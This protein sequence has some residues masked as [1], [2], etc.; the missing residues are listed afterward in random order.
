MLKIENI[1]LGTW[2]Q[3]TSLHLREFFYFLET[4]KSQLG[5]DQAKL[6]YFYRKLNPAQVRWGEKEVFD[7]VTAKFDELE[8]AFFEDGIILIKKEY[9]DLKKDL[10]ILREFYEKKFS[11]TISYLYSLGAPLPKELAKI[12]LILPYIIVASEADEKEIKELFSELGD[13]VRSSAG[14]PEISLYFGTELFLLVVKEFKKEDIQPEEIIK[15]LIFFREFATQLNGYLQAHRTIWED[16]SQIRSKP[17]LRFRDFPE[18]RNSLMGIKQTL[19]FVEARLGQM[20]NF[21]KIRQSRAKEK[22]LDGVLRLL[23]IY[24]F[25]TLCNTHSY[26]TDLW[27]MTKDYADSTFSLLGMFYQENIQREVDALKL[28]TIISLAAALFRLSFLPI[29]NYNLLHPQF[30]GSLV[31][32]FIF[33]AIFYFGMRYWFRSRKFELQKKIKELKDR[34]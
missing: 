1:Y 2:F 28:I 33:A 19:S 27:K 25:D 22:G 13:S 23:S 5:L 17:A 10:R 12:E 3:R 20:E 7:N 24:E 15:Y 31:L 4:G 21:I 11:P 6:A 8:M 32:I 18:I 14:T 30:W 16:I 29:P 34:G 9:Q 26:I